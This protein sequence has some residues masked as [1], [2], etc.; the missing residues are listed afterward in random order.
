MAE[1][2]DDIVFQSSLDINK[3]T[4]QVQ[5]TRRHLTWDLAS[6]GKPPR[7]TGSPSSQ[8]FIGEYTQ[9]STNKVENM[10]LRE[11]DCV[12]LDIFIWFNFRCHLFIVLYETIDTALLA[13][14]LNIGLQESCSYKF[15]R[16]L[17]VG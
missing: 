1:C 10:E 11:I 14:Q 2:G 13:T 12:L 5:L 3:K 7:Q 4:H 16:G 8:P 9:L 6:P 15:Q 17:D